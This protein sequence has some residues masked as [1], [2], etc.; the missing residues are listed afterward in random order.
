MKTG[1]MGAFKRLAPAGN[2]ACTAESVPRRRQNSVSPFSREAWDY[3]DAKGQLRC[4]VRGSVKSSAEPRRRYTYLLFIF[5]I[6]AADSTF[7][8]RPLSLSPFIGIFFLARKNI[9]FAPSP[10]KA[11]LYHS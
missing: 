7:E 10:G 1:L 2:L 9:S 4:F 11:G 6:P 3:A 5:I 8:V